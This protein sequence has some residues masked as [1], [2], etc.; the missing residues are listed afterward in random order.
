MG[1][2]FNICRSIKDETALI[3]YAG[4]EQKQLQLSQVSRIIPGQRTRFPQSE[5]EYQ[6]F[7]LL[8]GK[9]SLDMICKDN[10]EAE[11]WFVALRALI[12]RGDSKKWRTEIRADDALSDSSTDQTERRS[13]NSADALRLSYSSAITTSRV[14]SSLGDTPLS[15]IFV[16]GE[17]AGDGLLDG[18]MARVGESF[19]GKN[20]F[21]PKVLESASALDAQNI[22]CGSTHAV[23]V[24]RQGQAFSWGD[25]SGGK[26][27]HGLDADISRPK[28]ID[29]LGGL[30]V[31]SVGCGEY[32]A[33]AITLTGDLY[34][35]G[36]GIHNFG[37]LGHGTELSYWIPRKVSGQIEGICVTSI[38]C[39]PWDS[40]AI[41]SQG[42]LFTLGDGTFGALGHGD[43]CSTN[44]PREVE[45]LKGQKVVRISCGF[46]HTAAIVGVP[47][48]S[49][50][51]GNS[52]RGK[53]FTWGNGDGGQL[54]H[55]D[56]LSRLAPYCV[57]VPNER[58]FFQDSCGHSIKL[59]SPSADKYIQWVL[60]I[61][62]N[63]KCPDNS[64]MLPVR[65]EGTIKN[66]VMKEISC[67]SH[68]VAAVASTSEIFTWGKEINGQ[69]GQGDNTNRHS[70]TLVKALEGKHVKGITCGNN[71]TVA[72]CLHQLDVNSRVISSPSK[73]SS[74]WLRSNSSKE[75]KKESPKA[76]QHSVLSRL[77]SFGSLRRAEKQLPEKNE[78]LDPNSSHNSSLYGG[79]TGF[80]GS[81]S[82]SPSTSII[83]GC[84]RINAL[85]P[86]NQLS[87]TPLII[88]LPCHPYQEEVIG[89]MKQIH[90]DLVE[91]ISFSRE[92]V[93]GL[94]QKSQLLAAE[95]E[96]TS[97]QLDE[98]T[99]WFQHE[100]EKN[101]GAKEAI[102][103][104]MNQLKDGFKDASWSFFP[105][106]W[107]F[108]CVSRSEHHHYMKTKSY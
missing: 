39:G 9:K 37:L 97:F 101:N 108:C 11:I 17:G 15:S 75:K 7:S 92:Q 63:F 13:L 10:Y 85:V 68:H 72:I 55:G 19:P 36:D 56:V 80:D 8:Y 53:L 50:S 23:L 33:C 91:E 89:D 3:W 41:T 18:G 34:T 24:T 93:E 62:E 40:A 60:L 30:N 46:W 88:S 81:P 61:M 98:A 26:L 45:A 78:K 1:G 4:K 83:D 67:G 100:S 102:K 2:Y 12:S 107:P 5:K 99:A 20:A 47:S 38:S 105:R 77:S 29:A 16:W 82:S 66:C 96:R 21:M 71:F 28:L 22:A 103:C 27:G 73:S 51:C 74:L 49:P 44:V 35:W 43:R 64:H 52:P 106:I 104:L 86:V 94:A 54:G 90:D 48:E 58:S 59:L 70:P 84:D 87:V 42:Q 69:L 65:V 14:E 76:L 6:S 95:L 31:V 32:H 79:N 25:G 57:D